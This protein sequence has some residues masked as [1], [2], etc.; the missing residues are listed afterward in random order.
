MARSYVRWTKE[1]VISEARKYTTIRDFSKNNPMAYQAAHR[2]RWA[3]EALAHMERTSKPNGYWNY[4]N[5]KA[6]A[7]KYKTRSAFANSEHQVAYQRALDNL[8]IEEFFPRTGPRR[9]VVKVDHDEK[10]TV[11]ANKYLSSWLNECDR[12][13]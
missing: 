9:P 6:V 13:I 8:W 10:D 3:D 2:R 11:R 12:R 7:I 4:E 5:V 1:A